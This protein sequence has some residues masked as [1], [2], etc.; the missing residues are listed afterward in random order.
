MPSYAMATIHAGLDERNEALDLL[1][2]AFAEKDSQM[3]FLKVEPKWDPLRRE[4]RF[5]EL[6]RKM[7]FE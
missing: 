1:E 2:K 7:K 5:V 6:M 3:V 4:P